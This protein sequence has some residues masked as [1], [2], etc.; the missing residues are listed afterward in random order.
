MEL[1][2]KRN[3]ILLRNILR[4]VSSVAIALFSDQVSS[5]RIIPA[6][7]YARGNTVA[8][9][10]LRSKYY[11]NHVCQVN[12]AFTSRIDSSGY[13]VGTSHTYS[14]TFRFGD[15]HMANCILGW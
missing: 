12:Y 8:E 5:I 14:R 6:V 4:S 10:G 15:G 13:G 1:E 2:N 9:R 3:E 11:S 7:V